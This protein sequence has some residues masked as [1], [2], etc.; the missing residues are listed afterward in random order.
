GLALARELHRRDPA[1]S[2]AVLEKEDE[3]GVHQ[4]GHSS[5]VI[6][7]WIYYSPC[8]LKAR[9][10]VEGAREL[11]EFCEERGV[12]FERCGKVIVGL[13][14]AGLG[15]LDELERR[16]IANGVPGLRRINGEELRELEP[17]AAGV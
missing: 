2:I 14:D 9:L 7:A 8:S 11:Y 1:L 10:C 3:V 17:H 15:R 12:P 6:H 16:G 13:D 5:G 4:T